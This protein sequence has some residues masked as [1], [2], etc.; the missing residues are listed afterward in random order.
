MEALALPA[1]GLPAD[2]QCSSLAACA[3]PPSAAACAALVAAA[4]PPPALARSV[5][6]ASASCDGSL[7]S[8]ST[9]VAAPVHVP[10]QQAAAPAPACQQACDSMDPA[11]RTHHLLK[12]CL[13][14]SQRGA[15]LQQFNTA[16]PREAAKEIARMGQRELQAKFKVRGGRE[17]ARQ[18]SV[19][20]PGRRRWCLRG[21]VCCQSGAASPCGM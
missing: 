11:Q 17:G 3:A 9:E 12:H 15:A 16:D 7:E 13:S 18:P 10:A 20:V 1:L 6:E 8:C 19:H 5:P 4:A 2:M 14:Q 21:R